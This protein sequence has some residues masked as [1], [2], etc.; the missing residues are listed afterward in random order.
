LE[1]VQK[2]KWSKEFFFTLNNRYCEARR[3]KNGKKRGRGRGEEGREREGKRE[4]E[5]EGKP[6]RSRKV[7]VGEDGRV[8][9]VTNPN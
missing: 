4:G 9:L 1:L 5:G 3:R 6:R 7:E 2:G 8:L